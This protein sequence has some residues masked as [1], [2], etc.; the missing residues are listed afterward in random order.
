MGYSFRLAARILLHAS[1]H[2]QDD[3]NHSL[4]YTS[5]GEQA[6]TRNSSMG[7]PHEG[8]IRRPIAPWANALT[9][10]LHLAL[11]L[12]WSYILLL[13]LLLLLL[14]TIIILFWLN[15]TGHSKFNNASNHP[16]PATDS[17][18]TARTPLYPPV[19]AVPPPPYSLPPLFYYPGQRNRYLCLWQACATT[20]CF[21]CA[22]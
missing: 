6:G 4:C 19:Q 2:R 21:V 3:T 5:R 7:P 8:S 9:T 16:P 17:G 20:A 14:L 11:L 13:L 1:S 12:P 18:R 22:H 10:E 15:R